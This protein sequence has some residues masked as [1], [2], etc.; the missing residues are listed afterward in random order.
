MMTF[1]VPQHSFNFGSTSDTNF[2]GTPTYGAKQPTKQNCPG[3]IA[4]QPDKSYIWRTAVNG[5]LKRDPHRWGLESMGVDGGYIVVSL[6]SFDHLMG[7]QT[8][9]QDYLSNKISCFSYF[10]VA[11]SWL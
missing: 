1:N 11:S 8:I 9:H 10:L 5:G 3:S 4:V 6:F 7:V 2:P